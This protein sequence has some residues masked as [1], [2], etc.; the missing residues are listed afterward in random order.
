MIFNATGQPR[1]ELET[2]LNDSPRLAGFMVL[3]GWKNPDGTYW[4][5]PFNN[6]LGDSKFSF[7]RFPGSPPNDFSRDQANVY[8]AGLWLQSD[9]DQFSQWSIQK[10]IIARQ[11][12]NGDVM[13]PGHRGHLKRC[14][15]W[16][17]SW[18]ENLWLKADIIY[19]AKTQY[20]EQNQI[21]AMAL[22]AGPSYVQLWKKWLPNWRVMLR[23]YWVPRGELELVE[24]MI[25]KLEG[26]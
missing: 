2:D 14:I 6:Y 3:A 11:Y 16:P 8:C 13:A 7:V 10:I 23:S 26:Y 24:L 5:I 20:W 25:K 1:D 18:I 4:K 15:N 22:V 9:K 19:Q 21:L 12:P 17:T